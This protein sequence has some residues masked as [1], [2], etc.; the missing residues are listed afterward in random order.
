M[1]GG[2]H[3]ACGSVWW[4]EAGCVA[5]CGGRRRQ[6]PAAWRPWRRQVAAEGA[7]VQE[8]DALDGRLLLLA[9]GKKNKLL[10]RIEG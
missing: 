2:Q 9:S 4:H 1:R 6:S 3:G 7:V 10:V 5:R 8:G